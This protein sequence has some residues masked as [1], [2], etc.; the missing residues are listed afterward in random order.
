MDNPFGNMV[1]Q[2]QKMQEN[3]KKAQQELADFTV[4]GESGAGL[5]KITTNGNGDTLKVEIDDSV[6]NDDKQVLQDLLMS[7]FNDVKVK[8][9]RLRN[10]KLKQFMGGMGLPMNFDFPFMG[11]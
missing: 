10:E 9:E 7:A 3:M 11:G 4:V 5:V 6:Y 2:I 1:Q 8:R